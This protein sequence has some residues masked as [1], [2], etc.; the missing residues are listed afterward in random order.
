MLLDRATEQEE[1][2]PG[3]QP[4]ESCP[5]WFSDEHPR[6]D[7]VAEI[8]DEDEAMCPNHYRSPLKDA[9]AWHSHPEWWLNR[10]RE[11]RLSC[12]QAFGGERLAA[13]GTATRSTFA[14]TS[15]VAFCTRD[16][17]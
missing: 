1:R 6:R 12:H 17:A 13:C 16:I 5:R 7:G 3:R 4:D 9:A 2:T 14:A 15:P 10:R 11:I 8:A